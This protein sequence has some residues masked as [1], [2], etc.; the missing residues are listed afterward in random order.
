MS[1]TKKIVIII[2][3]AVLV[4]T[5][6]VSFLLFRKIKKKESYNV[7]VNVT[8]VVPVRDGE[9]DIRSISSYKKWRG[10]EIKGKIVHVE[11]KPNEVNGTVIYDYG[12]SINND[13][14]TF[15]VK[16]INLEVGDTVE[17]IYCD[18]KFDFKEK[19]TVNDDIEEVTESD[20]QAATESDTQVTTESY[21]DTEPGQTRLGS[22]NLGYI[23][24]DSSW[25]KMDIDEEVSSQFEDV[26][27]YAETSDTAGVTYICFAD[28]GKF[29]Y[30]TIKEYAETMTSRF[31]G[32]DTTVTYAGDLMG[33]KD[34]VYGGGVK[35]VNSGTLVNIDVYCFKGNDGHYRTLTVTYQPQDEITAGL[36][37]KYTLDSGIMP[38]TEDEI[39]SLKEY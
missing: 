28:S 2:L 34:A 18:G 15:Y 33:F 30:V 23:I 5:T 19:V 36:W 3:I 22:S 16:G 38:L 17:G 8:E 31:V 13:N 1:K 12:D 4:I 6:T 14:I 29:D 32:S 10:Q 7:L 37:M 26:E 21:P 20:T 9:Y 39:A 24:A 35:T 27:E 11:P 25:V